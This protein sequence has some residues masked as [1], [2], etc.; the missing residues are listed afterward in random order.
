MYFVNP[1]FN[2]RRPYPEPD[3]TTPG[4]IPLPEVQF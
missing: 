4:L 1:K 2:Y 3:Q